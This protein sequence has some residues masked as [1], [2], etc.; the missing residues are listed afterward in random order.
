[1]YGGVTGK[2]REGL[3]MSILSSVCSNNSSIGLWDVPDLLDKLPYAPV[4][5][6]TTILYFLPFAEPLH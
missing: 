4:S 1:M 6:A 5:V 3:P 2:A